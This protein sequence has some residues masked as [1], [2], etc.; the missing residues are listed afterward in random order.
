M[1][2]RSVI[3]SS[4]KRVSRRVLDASIAR[5]FSALASP[6][7]NDYASPFKEY[8]DSM[9]R[10]ES[11]FDSEPSLSLPSRQLKCGIDEDALRFRTVHYGRLMLPPHVQGWEHRVTVKVSLKDLPIQGDLELEIFR[12]IVGPRFNQEKGELQLSSNQFGSRIEN[13]RHLVSML[14]RII[15][16][17]KRLAAQMVEQTEGEEQTA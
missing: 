17:S 4:S 5:D 1:A 2:L 14:D 6:S 10:G 11:M 16:G 8:F 3:L 13:K 9:E 7:G 15:V 12:Q